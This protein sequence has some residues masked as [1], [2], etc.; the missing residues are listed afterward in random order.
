MLFA[1]FSM[2]ES[3]KMWSIPC[4]SSVSKCPVKV[5]TITTYSYFPIFPSHSQPMVLN[6]HRR[7]KKKSG[8]SRQN[9]GFFKEKD[10]VH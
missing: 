5:C 9:Y 7:M 8:F 4:N 2:R 1:M 6:N 10:C 3:Q